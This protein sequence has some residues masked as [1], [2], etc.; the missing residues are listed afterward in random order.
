MAGRG[1]GWGFGVHRLATHAKIHKG[2]RRFHVQN[3]GF[4][5]HLVRG[6][7]GGKERVTDEGQQKQSETKLC[8]VMADPGKIYQGSLSLVGVGVGV[9]IQG[10]FQNQQMRLVGGIH[11]SLESCMATMWRSWEYLLVRTI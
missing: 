7:G 11:D 4:V 1:G 9:G 10:L 3:R 2:M 8:N 6:G 5:F